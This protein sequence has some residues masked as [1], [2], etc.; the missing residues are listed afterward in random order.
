MHAT[1]VTAA[2]SG[3]HTRAM[4][5]QAARPCADTGAPD[6]GMWIPERGL[7]DTDGVSV[8]LFNMYVGDPCDSDRR[9][10]LA[11]SLSRV[12][13][14]KILSCIKDFVHEPILLFANSPFVWAPPSPPRT[15]HTIAQN[16]ISPRPPF[17]AI[18]A[19]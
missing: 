17:I 3:T 19:I 4:G 11:H 5:W 12:G 16:I 18:Y 15:V 10:A 13:L 7:G 8:T 9:C 1:L 6:N 14:Y 2:S